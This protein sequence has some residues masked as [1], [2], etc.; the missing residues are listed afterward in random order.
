MQ[1]HELLVGPNLIVQSSNTTT[2][3]PLCVFRN[4]VEELGIKLCKYRHNYII[5]IRGQTPYRVITPRT[6]L[7]S[8]TSRQ[9]RVC[10][11]TFSYAIVQCDFKL[12]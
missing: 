3:L 7:G 1:L 8:H 4:H 10:C 9:L 11:Y 5:I 12:L 6:E 2:I